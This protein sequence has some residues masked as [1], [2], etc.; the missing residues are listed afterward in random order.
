MEFIQFLFEGKTDDFKKLFSDKYT[1][2]QMDSIIKLS[3]DIDPKH[4]YLIWIGKTLTKPVFNNNIAF[5]EELSL[6]NEL[7]KKFKRIGDNL[8]IK[9]IGQYKSLTDLQNAIQVYENRI[10][11]TIKKVEGAEIIYEDDEYTIVHPTTWQASCFYGQGSRWCTASKDTSSYWNN[12][13]LDAKLFYFLSKKLPTNNRFYKVALLQYYNGKREFWDAPNNPFSSGWILNTPYMDELL[14]VIDDYFYAN[15][16]EKIDIFANKERAKSEMERLNRLQIQNRINAKI[17]E[18]NERRETDEWNP[19]EISHG[20]I[21][22]KAWALFTYLISTNNDVREKGPNHYERVEFIE[23]ELE[24]L[25]E[26]QSELEANGGDLTDVENQISELEEEQEILSKS[27]DV[28]DIIPEGSYYE[29]TRF[30]VIHPDLEDYEYSVGD[31]EQTEESAK[32][33]IKS[34]ID[35]LGIMNTFRKGYVDDFIDSDEVESYAREYYESSVYDSP[36]SYLDETDR[37]LSRSQEKEIN[38]YEEKIEKYRNFI[39]KA[40]ERQLEYE[41]DS[42]KWKAIQKGIEKLEDLISDLEY[43]IEAIKE[44]PDGD[45]DEDKINEKIDEL[46][47][48]AA[49]NPRSFFSEF[50]I[51]NM[52]PF[53]KIDDVIDSV[54][55]DDGYYHTLNSYDGDGDTITWDGEIYY[56]MNTD[57]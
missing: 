39:E 12:K 2:E 24:R 34:L 51:E 21:G 25:S 29:L 47:S 52:E 36:E 41:T 30:S 4:K 11:R 56:I 37:M 40:T 9:D 19:E 55:N 33:S 46:S 5:D 22:A 57:R 6:I 7:L 1:E 43:D 35:D 3:N 32:E 45:W 28:Y 16:K 48:E 13:N 23:S 8:P 50:G 42:G 44:E 26:L 49:D 20:D 15:Y 31:E 10:R 54:I 17:E 18:A 38:E 53:I 14:K 27:I